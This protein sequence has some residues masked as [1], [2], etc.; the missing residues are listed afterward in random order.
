MSTSRIVGILV[1]AVA[2]AVPAMAQTQQPA[3]SDKTPGVDARQKIQKERIKEGV[4][5]GELTKRE[6]RG[7]VRQQKKIQRHEAKAK[8]DGEVTPQERA[9]LQKEQNRASRRIA[10]QKHDRQDRN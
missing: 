5:S 3:A 6:T 1:L 10:R 2:L 8:A 7:L 9:R 4:K